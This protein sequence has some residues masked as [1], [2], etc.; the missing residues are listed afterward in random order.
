MCK[1]PILSGQ[2]KNYWDD[3]FETEL[4][5]GCGCMMWL[6]MMQFNNCPKKLPRKLHVIFLDVSML[7]LEIEIGCSG[8]RA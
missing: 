6:H 2:M 5:L 1:H 8:Y 7:S 4:V 3:S